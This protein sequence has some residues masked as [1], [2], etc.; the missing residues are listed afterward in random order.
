MSRVSVLYR[1]YLSSVFLCYMIDNNITISR[2]IIM[3]SLL[4]L[5]VN[6]QRVVTEEF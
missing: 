1:R 5:I 6:R 4:S 2:P 3:L